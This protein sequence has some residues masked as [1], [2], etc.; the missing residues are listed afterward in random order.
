MKKFLSYS[1]I[2]VVSVIVGGTITTFMRAAFTDQYANWRFAS[3]YWKQVE[4]TFNDSF[5]PSNAG[6][7][8][9][10]VAAPPAVLAAEIQATGTRASLKKPTAIKRPKKYIAPL[11]ETAEVTE[12][13]P[14]LKNP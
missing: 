5:S 11:P 3:R 12:P 8:Q 10:A 13:V 9:V 2:V 14:W 1:I 6:V 4:L 7:D